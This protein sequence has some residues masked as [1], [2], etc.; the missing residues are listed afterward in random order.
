MSDSTHL[1]WCKAAASSNVSGQLP[2]ALK[3]SDAEYAL[4][5]EHIPVEPHTVS[6]SSLNFTQQHVAVHPPNLSNL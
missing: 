6:F 1:L 4:V 3:P 2:P 5:P